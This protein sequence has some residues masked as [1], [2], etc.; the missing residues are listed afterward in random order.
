MNKKNNKSPVIKN[1][2]FKIDYI[3]EI[4]SIYLTSALISYRGPP[5][6]A[7]FDTGILLQGY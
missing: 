1:K 3:I 6:L 7:Y 2:V 4:Y 5:F